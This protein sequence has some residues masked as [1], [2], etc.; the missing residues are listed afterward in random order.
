MAKQQTKATAPVA[1]LDQSQSQSQPQTTAAPINTTALADISSV[2]CN[3][4]FKQIKVAGQNLGSFGSVSALQLR[5]DNYIYIRTTKA[6]QQALKEIRPLA[7]RLYNDVLLKHLDFTTG[8]VGHHSKLTLAMISDAL[9]VRPKQGLST[10]ETGKPTFDQ[11]RTCLKNL[12]QAGLISANLDTGNFFAS[13]KDDQKK[14]VFLCLLE[15]SDIKRNYADNPKIN[16]IIIEHYKN[17]KLRDALFSNYFADHRIKHTKA[18]YLNQQ[19][20][21]QLGTDKAHRLDNVVAILNFSPAYKFLQIPAAEEK[22]P[23]IK[24]SSH[25]SYIKK[26]IYIKNTSPQDG[27]AKNYFFNSFADSLPYPKTYLNNNCAVGYCFAESDLN[28]DSNSDKHQHHQKTTAAP[29]NSPIHDLSL[30]DKYVLDFNWQYDEQLLTAFLRL[31]GLKLSDVTT[32]CVNAFLFYWIATQTAHTHYVWHQKLAF[33]S[34]NFIKHQAYIAKA[35]QQEAED[36]AKAQQNLNTKFLMHANWQADLNNIDYLLKHCADGANKS[37]Y[38]WCSSNLIWFTLDN[39]LAE[40][41]AYQTHLAEQTKSQQGWEQYFV[42]WLFSK[43]KSARYQASKDWQIAKN[44]QFAEE[45]AAAWHK[46]NLAKAEKAYYAVIH[47]VPTANKQSAANNNQTTNA[48]TSQNQDEHQAAPNQLQNNQHQ[49][50]PTA[51]INLSPEEQALELNKQLG[52]IKCQERAIA[53][54][55][56]DLAAQFRNIKYNQATA[57]DLGKV[58]NA[59]AGLLAKHPNNNKAVIALMRKQMLPIKLI[60]QVF[61]AQAKLLRVDADTFVQDCLVHHLT[62]AETTQYEQLKWRK[63]LEQAS[64]IFTNLQTAYADQLSNG[65][66]NNEH[67]ALTK[68]DLARAALNYPYIKNH[69][70]KH[71]ELSDAEIASLFNSKESLITYCRNSDIA[72]IDDLKPDLDT[73]ISLKEPSNNN[74]KFNAE[75]LQALNAYIKELQAEQQDITATIIKEIKL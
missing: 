40:F 7:W 67:T 52:L 44:L 4:G 2:D 75:L 46:V 6:A 48:T 42:N 14:L 61:S 23:R 71:K 69:I 45:K 13:R 18:T 66:D 26:N 16:D 43:A 5:D 30:Q 49:P 1:L 9:Y 58:S 54:I 17:P 55:E 27:F 50:T 53:Q 35:E 64:Q 72:V 37:N 20:M 3:S 70:N 41:S 56:V 12:Q 51:N 73:L 60:E 31:Q 19:Q 59:L 15:A 28:L 8:I 34:Q 62:V 25:K 22:Q 29:I 21:Q 65:D 11:I 63:L 47:N 74:G 38:E 10:K 39:L 24:L 68:I 57:Q 32:E 33:H 36:L